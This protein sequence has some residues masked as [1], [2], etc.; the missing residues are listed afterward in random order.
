[1]KDKR[2]SARGNSKKGNDFPALWKIACAIKRQRSKLG[3]LEKTRLYDMYKSVHT[4]ICTG[5]STH[6]SVVVVLQLIRAISI[7]RQAYTQPAMNDFPYVG[8]AI[9][10]LLV[11]L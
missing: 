8:E 5:I 9:Q 6:V 7:H 4:Y 1:M 11:D 2:S 3:L 10:P